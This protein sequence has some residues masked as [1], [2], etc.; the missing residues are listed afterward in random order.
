M[1]QPTTVHNRPVLAHATVAALRLLLNPGTAAAQVEPPLDPRTWTK[2][3]QY[4]LYAG[5]VAATIAGLIQAMQSGKQTAGVEG[6]RAFVAAAF[7]VALV[8]L[9]LSLRGLTLPGFLVGA[10][11]ITAGMLSWAYTDTPVVV[12]ALLASEG[13]LFAI[14]S[15]PWLRGLARLPRIGAAWLGLAYWFLG[16]IGALLVWHPTVAAQRVA[17]CGVFTLAAIAVVVATRKSGRDLSVGITAAFLFLLALLFFAGSGNAL[18]VTH[19]VPP[20]AWGAHMEYRFWGAP[21]LLYHPNSIAVVAVMIAMRIGPDGAFERWQRYAALAVTTV[22]LLLVNSRTGLLYLGF[23]AGVHALLVLRQWY[24][25]RRRR[26]PPYDGMEVY[27]HTRAALIAALLPIVAVMVIGI[28]SGGLAFLTTSRYTGP[29]TGTVDVTSGRSSTWSVVLDEFKADSVAEKLFGDAKNARATVT[30]I[31][32]GAN[33]QDR[34]KLTTDNSAVG[35]LRRGGILGV[36]AYLI[37]LLLMVSHATLGVRGRRPQAWFAI[38]A[39]GSLTSIPFADW[40]LGGTGGTL[41]IYLLA[42]E[43]ALLFSTG[44]GTR[45]AV[46]QAAPADSTLAG[47]PTTSVTAA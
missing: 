28:G 35:A 12:W 41:W 23:A 8:G 19:A 15:F 5:L 24:A 30:R 25:Q 29:T 33:A 9:A 10:V 40:L 21:G 22:T 18:N 2:R 34:P 1:R 3:H 31:D 44:G 39:I 4:L 38:A 47:A 46:P 16:V 14:W 42:G 13:V 45:A 20:N 17:Y 37:G 6:V 7:A 11:F 32:T 27:G 43:A 26:V 36:A